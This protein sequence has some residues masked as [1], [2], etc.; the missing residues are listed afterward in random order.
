MMSQHAKAK[1]E[2]PVSRPKSEVTK[3]KVKRPVGRPKSAVTKSKV[4][5][6]RRKSH[7]HSGDDLHKLY[8]GS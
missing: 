5:V 3:S 6:A 4:K 1:P 7:N 2:A 8:W